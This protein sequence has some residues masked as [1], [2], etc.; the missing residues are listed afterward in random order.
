[1]LNFLAAHTAKCQ[2]DLEKSSCEVIMETNT[3][4]SADLLGSLSSFT[5]EVPSEERLV[6]D[7]SS[8][9]V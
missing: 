1:M 3:S 8:E 6:V 9:G 7:C 4:G 5:L 2:Y